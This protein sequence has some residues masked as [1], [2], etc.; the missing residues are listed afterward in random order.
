MNSATFK[1]G[2]GPGEKPPVN[3]INDYVLKDCE[4]HFIIVDD[5][6]NNT[7]FNHDPGTGDIEAGNDAG[8][9]DGSTITVNF[10]PNN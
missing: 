4:V 2:S 10:T 8:F 3:K 5:V 1:M 6:A 7:T 9:P